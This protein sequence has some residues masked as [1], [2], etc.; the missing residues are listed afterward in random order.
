MTKIASIVLL[1]SLLVLVSAGCE[2]GK[3][4]PRKVLDQCYAEK[5]DCVAAMPDAGDAMDCEY[6]Y[7]SCLREAGCDDEADDHC[8]G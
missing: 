4:C 5:E 2:D 1:S 7:C 6:A 8:D 3:G